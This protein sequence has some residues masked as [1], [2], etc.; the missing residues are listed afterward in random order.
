MGGGISS[1]STFIHSAFA[2]AI[3]LTM[4]LAITMLATL[5]EV[6]HAQACPD[7]TW[8]GPIS[9]I[10][11]ISTPSGPCTVTITYC[12]KDVNPLGPLF[13]FQLTSVTPQPGCTA[14]QSLTFDQ[15]IRE[16]RDLM[17]D[18]VE[19]TDPNCYIFNGSIPPCSGG[20]FATAVTEVSDCWEDVPYVWTDGKTY[21]AFYPCGMTFCTTT[22]QWCSDAN[23]LEHTCTSTDNYTGGCEALPSPD[24]WLINTCYDIQVCGGTN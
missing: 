5:P 2:R 6:S 24:T 10:G 13:E 16:A 7:D 20:T 19:S 12:Y 23:G 18:H 4:L 11:T 1:L 14:C 9:Y 15:L 8:T 21:D 3:G 17:I 22:C